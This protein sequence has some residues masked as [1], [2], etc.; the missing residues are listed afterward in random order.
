VQLIDSE[1]RCV[2]RKIEP[3]AVCLPQQI[4]MPSYRVSLT[5]RT[6]NCQLFSISK[7]INVNESAMLLLVIMATFSGGDFAAKS[8]SSVS[9]MRTEPKLANLFRHYLQPAVQL[10]EPDRSGKREDPRVEMV[11]RR[12]RWRSSRLRLW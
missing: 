5:S 9:L 2:F 6:C 11:T 12:G 10:A 4:P 7:G 3:E 8:R 1:E